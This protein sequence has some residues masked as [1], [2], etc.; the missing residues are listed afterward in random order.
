M[1]YRESFI[2]NTSR[3]QELVDITVQVEKIVR[4]SQVKNGICHI[5]S[6]HTTTAITVNENE[7]RL[8]EDFLKLLD[9]WVPRIGWSHGANAHSHLKSLIIGNSRTLPVFQGSLD[10]GTWQSVFFLEMD[11]PRRRQ[12]TVTVIGE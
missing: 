5:H 11:G 6:G 8:L 3:P 2:L 10:L 12:V 1:V 4:A 7:S 9:S